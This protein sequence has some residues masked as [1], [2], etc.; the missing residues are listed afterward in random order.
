MQ[1]PRPGVGAKTLCALGLTSELIYVQSEK[2][3]AFRRLS[4]F[5]SHGSINPAG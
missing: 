1:A 5:A 4:R 3:H 2:L